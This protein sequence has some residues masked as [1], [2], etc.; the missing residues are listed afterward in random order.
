MVPAVPAVTFA[1]KGLMFPPKL[2]HTHTHL[3]V[4]DE[5][6][7]VERR[8]GAALRLEAHA[9][10]LLRL[11]AHTH[12]HLQ[13]GDE[14]DG[15]ERRGGAALRLEAHALALLR[16][17]AVAAVVVRHQNVGGHPVR[18]TVEVLRVVFRPIRIRIRFRFSVG[19]CTGIGCEPAGFGTIEAPFRFNR[20]K[21]ISKDTRLPK[22]G[23]VGRSYE[24]AP[25][26]YTAVRHCA[27]PRRRQRTA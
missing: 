23:P 21:H 24:E 4:G 3:Q 22:P 26:G 8:G 27:G 5:L 16:L 19:S 11:L 13:V 14:L 20:V 15:V 9:L 25:A 10:A 12:T 18:P 7:G 2:A 1:R 17:L 6:D